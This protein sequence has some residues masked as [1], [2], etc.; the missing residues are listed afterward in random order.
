MSLKKLLLS[1]FLWG[2]L[3]VCLAKTANAQTC[4]D[5]QISGNS[6]PWPSTV[7]PQITINYKVDDVTSG[8][9]YTICTDKCQRWPGQND[10]VEGNL[11]SLGNPIVIKNKVA[12]NVGPHTLHIKNQVL[13]GNV[14]VCTFESTDGFQVIQENPFAACK[15]T[16]T[17]T[18]DSQGKEYTPKAVI[19]VSGENIPSGFPYHRL[20][21]TGPGFSKWYDIRADVNVT[22]SFPRLDINKTDQR[23][24]VGTYLIQF[25]GGKPTRGTG[26]RVDFVATA[27]KTNFCIDYEGCQTTFPPNGTISARNICAGD[28]SGRCEPCFGAGN[29]WTALGCIE[30]SSPTKFAA[31]F[32]GAAIF[33]ATGIAFLLMAFGAIQILTSAGDPEQ[34]KGGGQ[35]I[36]SA[37]SGLIFIILSVF[38]LQ[39][40]GVDILQLPGFG[41]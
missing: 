5:W 22:Q 37:V 3:F 35:L 24:S 23:L 15:L 1:G 12:N 40:I 8:D 2:A 34:V 17:S 6:A 7:A 33:I 20:K 18:T 9:K 28:K 4:S 41:K 10:Y 32:L 14:D 11:T 31:W 38:L 21:V 25:Y 26:T 36:T 29:T 30:T 39:L 27:C 16:V 13:P 19:S